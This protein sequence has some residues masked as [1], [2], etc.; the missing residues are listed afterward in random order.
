MVKKQTFIS[1][2]KPLPLRVKSN[3]VTTNQL[4]VDGKLILEKGH[5]AKK[6]IKESKE[7]K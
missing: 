6:E 1:T 5:E 3:I 2:T 4:D 7:K